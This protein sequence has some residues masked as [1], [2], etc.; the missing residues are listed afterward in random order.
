MSFDIMNPK[1]PRKKSLYLAFLLT[2][3]FG[4]LG[5]LYLSWKRAAVSL[6]LFVVGVYFFPGEALVVVGLWLIL[7]ASSVLA[8]SM[9]PRGRK[10]PPES[11]G[12]RDGGELQQETL[13][14]D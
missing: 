5:L 7:P 11:K 3:L 12:D 4:P 13:G 6:L 8:I 9:A 10:S 14:I 1:R 2:L